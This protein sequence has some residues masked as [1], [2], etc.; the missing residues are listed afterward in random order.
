MNVRPV[1]LRGMTWNHTRGYLPLVAATQRF[2][3]LHPE[4]DIAWER[5]TLKAFEAFPV[6]QLAQEYDLIVID[7]PFIGE[8]AERGVFL[9]LDEWL[10]ADF[11]ADQATQSVGA[12]HRSYE[13][14]GHSWA[15]A[16]DAAAP[17][18]V[19][20]EDLLQEDGRPLPQTWDEVADL[21]RQGR[22]ELPA[23]PINCLMNF[24]SFCLAAGETPFADAERVVR[25]ETGREALERLREV[26][27]WCDPGCWERNPILSH[28]RLA[29]AL[30]GGVAYC[31]LAYGYSNYARA[32]YAA[33]RLRFGAPP[34]EHGRPLVTTLGGTGL[35][36]SALR[37]HPREAARFAR[38]A[39]SGEVQRTLVTAAGGQ[40]GHRRAWLDEENN[41]LTGDTFRRTLPVLDG[42]YLRPRYPG[43]VEFQEHGAPLVHA[44]LR[45]ELTDDEALRRLDEVYRRS[46]R[47]EEIA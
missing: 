14:N 1:L 11:L 44:A 4:I 25:R 18:A 15:L 21:A 9:P 42:A 33:H 22:V 30:S 6:E 7:H 19:W 46:L 13:F 37:P 26:L 43:H 35:A 2:H 38:F 47:T 10:P 32:G 40:P 39:A 8:A 12:S 23:A 20:R 29:A 3:E 31:P 41:R 34:S 5:R 16:I 28:E 17:V 45:G 36:L 24:Y 27:R